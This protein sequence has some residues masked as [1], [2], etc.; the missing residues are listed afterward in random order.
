MRAQ[1]C[2][3][4]STKSMG[5]PNKPLN[6]LA[7][8]TSRRCSSSAACL[9]GVG[10]FLFRQVESD[11]LFGGGGVNTDDRVHLLF[12]H[13]HLV[14]DGN[15]LGDLAGVGSADVEADD[16]VTVRLVH[17]HLGVGSASAFSDQLVNGPLEGLEL[18]VKGGDVFCSVS[19]L[20]LLLSQTDSAVFERSEHGSGHALVVHHLGAGASEPLSEKATSPNG[21]WRQLETTVKHVSDGEDVLHVRLVLLVAL[22]LAVAFGLDAGI[23]TVK[24]LSHGVAADGEQNSVICVALLA[25][26]VLPGH[27]DGTVLRLTSE[28][29]G[30][31]A[32]NELGVVH[33]HVLSDQVGHILVE[34]T[35]QDGSDHHSRV[36]AVSDEESGALKGNI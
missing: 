5:A 15:T 32:I 7:R 8:S 3:A 20:C 9:G 4:P 14:A 27:C 16:A 33:A 18:R 2:R 30:S 28:A 34:P 22:E 24:S 29:L 19:L 23:R 13:A 12:G 17:Q 25:L 31:G 6:E 11:D 21:D 36:K 10:V 35:Q 1:A 26:A